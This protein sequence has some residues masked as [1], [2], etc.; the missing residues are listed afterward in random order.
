MGNSLLTV[1][2]ARAPLTFLIAQTHDYCFFL[3]PTPFCHRNRQIH[4]ILL[5]LINFSPRQ[6][7]EML[8]LINFFKANNQN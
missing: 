6:I 1:A 4:Q 5:S 8:S 2:T 7:K 3:V